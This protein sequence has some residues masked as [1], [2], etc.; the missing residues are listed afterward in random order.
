[1]GKIIIE[2][3]R[4]NYP[5]Y[6]DLV[7]IRKHISERV[8][9]LSEKKK[10]HNNYLAV[11]TILKHTVL[12]NEILFIVELKMTNY[13]YFLFKLR[14]TSLCD[15]PFFRFDSDGAPHRNYDETIPLHLQQITTPHFNSFNKDG[16]SIAYKTDKLKDDKERIALEDISLCI[17]HFC[18]ESNIRFPLEDF[19]S[20]TIMA[21]TLQL[22]V[23]K[24]DPNAGV[25]FL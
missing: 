16:L 17:V 2:K 6:T 15:I 12:P 24:D 19:P 10:T 23:T 20:I 14:C 22:P 11:N 18:Y 5:L 8:L 3:I 4:D 21:G 1:M 13:K 25:Q 9:D 7:Q